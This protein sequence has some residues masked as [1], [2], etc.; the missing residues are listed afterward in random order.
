MSKKNLLLGYRLGFGLLGFSA[1]VTEIAVLSDRDV[2]NPA[3]FFSYFTIESNIIAVVALLVSA[4]AVA[5]NK[6]HRSVDMLRGA[7]TLYILITGVV[8]SVLLANLESLTA[9]PW[10]NIVL[11]YIMPVVLIV[12]WFVDPPKRRIT[13]SR[14]LL[15]L[16]YPIAY[17]IYS[18]IR[19]EITSWYPYPFLNPASNGWSAVIVTSIGIAVGSAGLGWLLS[20]RA[21]TRKG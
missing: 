7:A 18:L 16:I 11:H 10:D 14:T 17:V 2:F 19:G 6:Q 12:D 3:N 9:T 5:S 4:V 13:F 15:W 21:R 20:L 8:F 1:I